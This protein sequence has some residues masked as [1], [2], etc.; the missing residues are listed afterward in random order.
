MLTILSHLLL[1][2]AVLIEC[3][4]ALD[5][6]QIVR[7]DAKIYKHFAVLTVVITACIGF[8][9]DTDNR[10]AIASEMDKRDQTVALRKAE[11]EKRAKHPV[12][13]NR[14]GNGPPMA[15]DLA[16]GYGAPTDGG[17]GR[18]TASSVLPGAG[19]SGLRQACGR[20]AADRNALAKMG[21]EQAAAY[22][23]KLDEMDCSK[24]AQ[25]SQ[26]HQPTPGEI[27]AL[28]AASAARSGSESVD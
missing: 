11:E 5:I 19:S 23:A 24:A 18:G 25:S 16:G 10:Q 1:N 8:F 17:S 9:A 26:P 2:P 20:S 14:A 28:A 3:P 15:D 22:L 21:K 7:V 4:M 12:L 13:E 27:S 6:N